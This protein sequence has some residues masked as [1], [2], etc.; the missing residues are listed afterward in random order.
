V[1]GR[2]F[3]TAIA[4]GQAGADFVVN[5]FSGEECANEV[6]HEIRRAGAKTYAQ[7]RTWYFIHDG[8]GNDRAACRRGPRRV[9]S[10]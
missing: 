4:L 9:P 5:Y 1:D 3:R 7:K 10:K 8:A 6:V 2:Q